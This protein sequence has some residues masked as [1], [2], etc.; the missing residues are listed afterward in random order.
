MLRT[1]L[2]SR[3]YSSCC[4]SSTATV[5]NVVRRRNISQSLI[6]SATN[7]GMK[8]EKGD[9]KAP[10]S[11]KLFSSQTTRTSSRGSSLLSSPTILSSLPSTLHRPL[12]VGQKMLQQQK[13][14]YI[15]LPSSFKDLQKYMKKIFD[16][17]NTHRMEIVL[18]LRET[19]Q[20]IRTRLKHKQLPSSLPP[21]SSYA[22]RRERISTKITRVRSNFTNTK[23][24]I[25]AKR[26]A[27]K[28]RY[29][30][31]LLRQSPMHFYF[32][33]RTISGLLRLKGWMTVNDAESI[34][35]RFAR[36]RKSRHRFYDRVRK[37]YSF[38]VKKQQQIEEGVDN[39]ADDLSQSKEKENNYYQTKKIIL[40]EPSSPKWFDKNGYPL[41][42]QDDITG[43]FVNPWN[44][45][46]TDGD[47]GI[48]DF[49]RW[50]WNRI[51]TKQER[52]NYLVESSSNTNG[53]EKIRAIV[54]EAGFH[55]D[56]NSNSDSF[57]SSTNQSQCWADLTPPSNDD[58][59]KLTWIGH[60]TALIQ[61]S[62]YT[63]LTDPIFSNRASPLQNGGILDNFTESRY[64]PPACTV[65]TLPNVI[66]AVLIS[67]DH[68]DHLDYNSVCELFDSQK[69]KFW[70]VPLGMKKW[71]IDRVGVRALDIVELKW[72]EGVKF[73]KGKGGGIEV[74]ELIKEITDSSSNEKD[75]TNLFTNEA[76]LKE[77]EPNSQNSDE[78]KLV[79]MVITCAPAQH[80]CSR[81][82]F[83]RNQRLWCSWAV[84]TTVTNPSTSTKTSSSLTSSS[85]TPSPLN[86]YFAGDTGLPQAFPLHR[87]IGDRL[88]PFQ[89]S[90]LP[91]GA[92][93]PSFFMRDSHCNP[94]EA[95]KMHIDL[96]S[97]RSVGVHWGTFALADETFDEPPMM[98]RD[99]L[100]EAEKERT[101]KDRDEEILSLAGEKKEGQKQQ[102]IDKMNG[103]P[104][105]DFV[106]VPQGGSVESCRRKYA[107][108]GEEAKWIEAS[109]AKNDENGRNSLT[110]DTSLSNSLEK[111]TGKRDEEE[112]HKDDALHDKTHDEND[113]N[114]SCSSLSA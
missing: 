28:V 95:V 11:S 46:S 72:W 106:V 16:A 15:F 93:E 52:Q 50:R 7:N 45:D 88:G 22:K 74:V 57:S 103:T 114:D 29:A 111:K 32:R 100:E 86:F 56:S 85:T 108:V 75:G 68:Y 40:N 92:Y 109:A 42:S 107:I 24:R 31:F 73:N 81:S 6:S 62:S 94:R 98:L 3:P 77:Y 53:L 70:I 84:K 1:S 64:V 79:E 20:S 21:P 58:K 80:W 82:P 66:D 2:L 105:V 113:D 51:M 71:L 34:R 54:Q 61:Q 4:G 26:D 41:T 33:R 30:N 89:L 23:L 69:V 110:I 99:A 91:I 102:G 12:F 87:Q 17:T 10:S 96:K 25:L 5:M 97:E 9:W 67:H 60:S 35:R 83:D 19:R 104:F 63:L 47:N 48:W 8:K 44:S 43:R 55:T 38:Y 112:I 76:G 65:S 59:I 37:N 13:R 39:K 90:A 101:I 78:N 49:I 36:N 27:F 18:K 14:S